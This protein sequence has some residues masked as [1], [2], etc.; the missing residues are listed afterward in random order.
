MR[1]DPLDPHHLAAGGPA[2]AS[3]AAL[4]VHEIAGELRGT[5]VPRPEARIVLRFGGAAQ[6]GLDVHALGPREQVHRKRVAGGQRIVVARLRLGT[7]EAVL[8]APASAIA[9][10]PVALQD[11]WDDTAPLFDRLAGAR[12]LAEAAAVLEGAI[13]QRLHGSG[14]RDA[15]PRLAL[16]AARRLEAANVDA[17]A[18]DLGVSARHLRRVFRQALGMG[19]KAFARLARFHRALRDARR[20]G[21]M[22][23]ADIAA[24]AGYYDQAHLIAEFRAIA[25][26]TPRAL[27]DELRAGPDI[28]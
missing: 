14:V 17:V 24:S 15:P 9:G 13:V 18:A 27:V 5:L 20:D 10:G 19:P 21:R 26:V 2:A 25:G 6:G 12:S 23:W 7:H 8:G 11:L 28:G 16:E 1:R 3:V 22:G 4:S